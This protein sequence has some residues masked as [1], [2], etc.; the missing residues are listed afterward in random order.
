MNYRHMGNKEFLNMVRETFESI[1][2][3]T[4]TK[5]QEYAGDGSVNTNQHANFDRW[6]AE[7]DMTP[8]KALKVLLNKHL[9]SINT[10]VKRL[11][12][13]PV[14]VMPA[15]SEPM[16]GRFDDAILFLLLMKGMYIRRVTNAQSVF[17]DSIPGAVVYRDSIPGQTI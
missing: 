17:K 16:E 12:R 11:E 2:K 4:A 7:L 9:D 8:E 1:T 5:G 14:S 15:P 13:E 6:S 10:W 3:L